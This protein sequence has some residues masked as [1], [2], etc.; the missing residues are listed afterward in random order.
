MGPDG[1]GH[2]VKM[3]HNGIEYADMQFIAEAYDLLRGAGLEP[4]P[5]AEVLREWNT[6]DLDSFLIQ[7][8]A[9]VLAH[10]DAAT[11]RPF[12]DM[13]ADAAE[14]LGTG[15]WT[16]QSGLALGVP[17]NAIAESVFAPSAS[18]HAGLRAAARSACP[19]PTGERSRTPSS[20]SRM[21]GRRYGPPRWPRWPGSGGA[22]CIIRAR[23]LERV[24]QAYGDADLPTLLAAPTSPRSSGSPRTAG[25]GRSRSRRPE[26]SPSPASPRRWPTTTPGGAIGCRRRWSGAAGLLRRP[27][28]PARDREGVFHKLWSEDRTEQEV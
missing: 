10:V 1:A 5:I 7:I 19:V 16:V 3:V 6:G 15:R 20:W 26:G 28:L 8:T 18:G 25:A 23:L 13:V 27:H 2:F 21:S 9:E 22:G 12:V 4:T 24:R 17:T 11:G 14:Q